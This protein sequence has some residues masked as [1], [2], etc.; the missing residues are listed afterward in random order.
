MKQFMRCQLLT[1]YRLIF[2]Q[3]NNTHANCTTS[4]LHPHTRII[5][6]TKDFN[7]RIQD[8]GC[9]ENKS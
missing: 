6:D 1:L 8:T 5:I 9:K 2:Y 3:S 4:N 7:S